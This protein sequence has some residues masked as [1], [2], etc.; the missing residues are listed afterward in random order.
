MRR[1]VGLAILAANR[2]LNCHGSLY[3]TIWHSEIA[4]SA[5]IL[6]NGYNLDCL[7]AKYQGVDWRN[8]SFHQCNGRMNPMWESASTWRP[9]ALVAHFSWAAVLRRCIAD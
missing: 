8:S 5:A 9:C 4:A 2:V 7:L 1:Q 3:E 6:D